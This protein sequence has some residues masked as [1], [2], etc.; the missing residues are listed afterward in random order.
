MCSRAA[1]KLVGAA[2]SQSN[3]AAERPPAPVVAVLVAA[4]GRPERGVVRTEGN[5]AVPAACSECARGLHASALQP[6]VVGQTWRLSDR[7]LPLWLYW[8][9]AVADHTGD[10]S[11][12]RRTQRCRRLVSNLLAGCT[13][14]RLSRRVVCEAWRVPRSR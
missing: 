5:V 3:M 10:L 11:G 2:R 12:P 4:C 13:L 14:A 9:L 7:P 8:S 1:H 6:A